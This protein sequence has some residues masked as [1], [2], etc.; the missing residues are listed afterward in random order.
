MGVHTC[1]VYS[2]QMKSRGKSK[3]HAPRQEKNQKPE[4]DR[5][6]PHETDK[7]GKLFRTTEPNL[8]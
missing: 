7:Y 4:N 3:D 8:I 6:H 1:I 5:I 2:A